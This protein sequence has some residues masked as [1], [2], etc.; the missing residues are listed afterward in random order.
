MQNPC[1]FLMFAGGA[2]LSVVAGVI[3]SFLV[4]NWAWFANL[5]GKAKRIAFLFI[6]ILIGGAVTGLSY[7]PSL[8]CTPL[9]WWGVL[10]AVYNA[11]MAFGGGTMAAT[12]K[13]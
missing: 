1:E 6:C 7:I 9:G 4:D 2:G 10:L 5:P 3:F 8:G 11:F 12:R 13:L